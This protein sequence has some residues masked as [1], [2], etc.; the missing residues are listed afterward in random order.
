MN[1]DN[2]NINLEN[3]NAYVLEFLSNTRVK[4][5]FNNTGYI[6]DFYI[7]NIERGE[8]RDRLECSVYGSGYGVIS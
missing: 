7:V 5:K 6:A 4:V 8:F 3:K 1:T 2:F